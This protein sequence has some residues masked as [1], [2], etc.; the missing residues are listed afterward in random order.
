MRQRRL[1]AGALRPAL[2][3]ITGLARAAMRP[4]DMNFRASVTLST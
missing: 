2:M 3:T 1:G 4:A